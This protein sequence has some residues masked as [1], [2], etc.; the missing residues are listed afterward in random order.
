MRTAETPPMSQTRTQNVNGFSFTV[1]TGES[2]EQAL[3]ILA[4]FRETLLLFAR[5]SARRLRRRILAQPASACA[6]GC[7]YSNGPYYHGQ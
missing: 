3:N 4:R 2:T 7:A 1:Q 6:R 5:A